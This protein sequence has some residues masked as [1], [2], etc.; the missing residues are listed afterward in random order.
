MLT[1]YVKRILSLALALIMV[2]GMLPAQVFATEEETPADH[3]HC[4]VCLQHDCICPPEEAPQEEQPPVEVTPTEP[5]APAEQPQAESV[6][7]D[8]EWT[9]E[10][11]EI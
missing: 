2:L 3:E 5:E 10:M 4:E 1:N 6:Q 8:V 11:L 9:E 7:T